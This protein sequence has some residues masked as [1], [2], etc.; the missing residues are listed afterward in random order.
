MALAVCAPAFCTAFFV[1]GKFTAADGAIMAQIVV[2]LVAGL[3]ELQPGEQHEQ[4]HAGRASEERPELQPDARHADDG[5][6]DQHDTGKKFMTNG[7]FQ[8]ARLAVG[9]YNRTRKM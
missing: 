4:H 2:A 3:E 9:G 6:G 1:G 8:C 5:E 7:D